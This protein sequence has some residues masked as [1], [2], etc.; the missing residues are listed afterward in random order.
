[1]HLLLSFGAVGIGVFFAV[2]LLVALFVLTAFIYIGRPNEVLVFSGRK[3]KMADG[4][5][6]GTREIRGEWALQT[7][8]FESMVGRMDLRTIPVSINVQGAYSQG[9]IAL[10]VHAVANVKVSSQPV[11]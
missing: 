11:A 7:P 2:L 6:S 9:G 3:Q 4:T 10:N 1:M 5:D 8:Y